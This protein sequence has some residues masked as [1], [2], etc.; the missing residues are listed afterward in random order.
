MTANSIAEP[1]AHSLAMGGN[2]LPVT[3]LAVDI[4]TYPV[5]TWNKSPG[6]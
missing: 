2:P 1:K 4:H 5:G 3:S 6:T